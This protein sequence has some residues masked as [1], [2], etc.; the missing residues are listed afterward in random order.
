MKPSGVCALAIARRREHAFAL[1]DPNVATMAIVAI[2][3][4]PVASMR[5]LASHRAGPSVAERTP[6][7]SRA[8]GG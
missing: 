8:R 4:M 2:Q 7:M 5:E 3:L 6:P 1:G